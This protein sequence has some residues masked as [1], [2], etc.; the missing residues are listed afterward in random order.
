MDLITGQGPS[1][2]HEIIYFAEATLGAVRINDYKYRF[3]DQP[4]GWLGGTVK[5][6]FPILT[7]IRLDPFE[8]TGLGRSINNYS[9]FAYQ[10]WRFVFVQQVVSKFA[11]SFIEFPPMQTPASFNLEAVKEQVE[12]HIHHS[13]A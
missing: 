11:E 8:R 9:W 1:K 13:A 5:P 7:N 4:G 6:D 12:R 3:I 2:R 10:F